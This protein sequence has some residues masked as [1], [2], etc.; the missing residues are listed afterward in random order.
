MTTFPQ[1]ISCRLYRASPAVR[2]VDTMIRVLVC[3]CVCAL[4]SSLTPRGGKMSKSK[5]PDLS[6]NS[7]GVS[8]LVPAALLH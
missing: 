2:N 7:K 5:R 3:S 6:A 1:N 4:N 8:S